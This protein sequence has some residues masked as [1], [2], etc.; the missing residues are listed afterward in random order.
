MRDLSEY[1]GVISKANKEL[2]KKSTQMLFGFNLW[3][4]DMSSLREA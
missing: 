4:L 2:Q 1:Q 3:K